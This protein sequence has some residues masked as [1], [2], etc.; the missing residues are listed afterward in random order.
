MEQ[1]QG[2]VLE[3]A[4]NPEFNGKKVMEIHFPARA[5][6]GVIQRRNKVII[7]KG[8]TEI[9]SNDILI[10]FTTAEN[11]PQIKEYFKICG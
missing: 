7:P 6:I 5:I 2:E 3:I 1:G 8:D 4:V 9:H 11:A 10:I